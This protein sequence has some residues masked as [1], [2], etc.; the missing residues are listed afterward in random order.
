MLLRPVLVSVITLV[1]FYVLVS[2]VEYYVHGH[3]MH[4]SLDESHHTHHISVLN[5]M[6]LTDEKGTMFQTG[7][8]LGIFVLFGLVLT[9]CLV[10]FKYLYRNAPL[11]ALTFI[12]GVLF[13]VVTLLFNVV[14]NYEKE[15]M[16]GEDL[17]GLVHGIGP[18][19][20]LMLLVG[21]M[22]ISNGFK[23]FSKFQLYKNT[24]CLRSGDLSGD[25]EQE[26]QVQP[27]SPPETPPVP[28]S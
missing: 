6:S 27:P 3:V 7:F 15:G 18:N 5:D 14:A 12:T 10:L 17:T 20:V 21:Y 13:F 8:A 22:L 26:S 9:A 4:S 25:H 28:V 11:Y 2:F 16:V 23:E 19:Y 1:V 24:R